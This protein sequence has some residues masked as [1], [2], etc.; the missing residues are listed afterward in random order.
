MID[1]ADSRPLIAIDARKYG[2]E[3]SGI[4]RYTEGLLAELRHQRGDESFLG[5]VDGHS[6]QGGQPPPEER[7]RWVPVDAPFHSFRSFWRLRRVLTEPKASLFHSHN[8]HAPWFLPC[9]LVVTIHDLTPL[10]YPPRP[11]ARWGKPLLWLM[12]RISVGKA[13]RVIVPSEY[14]KRELQSRIGVA[15]EKVRVIPEGVSVRFHETPKDEEM[16]RTRAHYHLPEFF[17]LYVGRWRPHKNIP[18]MVRAFQEVVSRPGAKDLHL[19]V[20]GGQDPRGEH[21]FQGIDGQ[22]AQRIHFAGYVL[23]EDLPCLYA[24]AA[25][26]M[27]PSYA[28]GFG[29]TAL[30]AMAS[31]TPVVAANAGALP[32][33]CGDA[34]LMVS[35]HSV[36][37]MADAIT[38][39][40]ENGALRAQLAERG[41]ARAS[42]LTWERTARQTLAVYREVLSEA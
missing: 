38:S 41:R 22:P 37:E 19:V 30:E 34:A 29:L 10:L 2:S 24:S 27:A 8:Y 23:D 7:V 13:V 25:A 15:E 31:G 33:V 26:L 16:K 21:L 39:V 9:P 14:T 5:L 12:Y 42:E 20:A 35:P 28:E 3:G 36:D 32:E 1:R 11:Q 6:M 4:G 17:L 18:T 40:V